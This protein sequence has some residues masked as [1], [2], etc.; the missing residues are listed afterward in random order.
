M[1]RST[2]DLKEKDLIKN[3]VSSSVRI[4]SDV[5]GVVERARNS[6]SNGIMSQL[7]SKIPGPRLLDLFH[8]NSMNLCEMIKYHWPNEDE[9]VQFTFFKVYLKQL[10]KECF[11][12]VGLPVPFDSESLNDERFMLVGLPPSEIDEGEKLSLLN[13]LEISYTLTRERIESMP[14]TT[15]R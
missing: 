1:S 4:A 12:V 5:N 2:S 15:P 3:T 9:K 11:S 10:E 6:E 14:T 7:T 13:Q 8:E